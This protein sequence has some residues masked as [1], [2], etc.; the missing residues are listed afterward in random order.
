MNLKSLLF[1]GSALLGTTAA[2]AGGF[3]VNLGGQKNIGMGGVGTGLAIDH[4]A[5]FY[6]PGALAMVR[7]NGVQV[8]ANATFARI[9]HVGENGGTQSNLQ[10][11]IVTP[12]NLYASFGPAEGKWKAGIGVYT[13]FGSK[14]R[15]DQNWEGRTA[16]TDIDLKS[17]F[18]QPTVSYAITDQ[19]S[20]GAGLVV[21]AYGSVNLQ[22][23]LPLTSAQGNAHSELD[24]HADN[25]F[26][27]N[28]GIYYKPSEKISVGVS[29]RSKMEAKVKGGDVTFTN[30]PASVASNFAAKKFD[31]TLPLPPTATLGIGLMP[32]E[33]LTI[34]I[35]VNWVDWSDYKTLDFTFDQPINGNTTSTSKR[36]YDQGWTFRLGGQYAIGEKLTVRAGANYDKTPV[37]DG[38]V[39]PETPD[40]DR[41]GLSAGASYNVNEHFGVDV[42]YLFEDFMKRT[43]SLAELQAKGTADDRPAGTY[44]TYISIPGVGVH[45]NF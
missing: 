3:Q 31:V 26:G 43:Q 41:I 32:T 5:M 8:G 9:S 18:V 40:A 44:K 33:K 2:Q 29:Y 7:Q 24:G 36:E 42:S 17:I 12:F 14:L 38:F 34:G 37:K 22:R 15:Y 10:K 25:T 23:D 13:P 27:Y 30:I 21:L 35:D 1:A 16:L 4:A 6:N 19:L 28:A 45:Y 39:S 11:D 20:V